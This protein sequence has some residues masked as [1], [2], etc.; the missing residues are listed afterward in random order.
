[1]SSFSPHY[2]T[3]SWPRRLFFSCSRP[4]RRTCSVNQGGKGG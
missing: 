4:L 3:A 1:V 2:G